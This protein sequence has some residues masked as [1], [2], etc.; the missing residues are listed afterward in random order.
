MTL[1]SIQIMSQDVAE[2]MPGDPG[3]AMISITDPDRPEAELSP[4]WGAVLRLSF[5]DTYPVRFQGIVVDAIPM[6]DA[7]GKLIADFVESL[8]ET[9]SALVVH[10]RLGVSRSAGV[11]KAI[12]EFRRLD[13]DAGYEDFNGHVYAVT[14]R[15]LEEPRNQARRWLLNTFWKD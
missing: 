5:F 11:A 10:C 1:R 15:A 7:Q 2:T 13:F 4:G 12:A 6:G 3:T 14:K 9:I 8:P